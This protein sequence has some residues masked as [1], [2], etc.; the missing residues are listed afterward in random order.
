M[1][2]DFVYSPTPPIVALGIEAEFCTA[3]AARYKIGADSP[4]AKLSKFGILP[5]LLT[6]WR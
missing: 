2:F 3:P 6:A 5:N 4:T 1:L